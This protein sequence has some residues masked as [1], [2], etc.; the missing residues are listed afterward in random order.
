MTEREICVMEEGHYE[1]YQGVEAERLLKSGLIYI[2]QCDLECDPDYFAHFVPDFWEGP[3]NSDAK[4]AWDII[5][6][7]AKGDDI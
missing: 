1:Y 7:V 5:R 6:S 4:T 2:C 3:G